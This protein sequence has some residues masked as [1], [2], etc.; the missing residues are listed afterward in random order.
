MEILDGSKLRFSSETFDDLMLLAREFGH[1]SLI[2]RLVPQRDF[3]RREGNVHELLQELHRSPRNPTIEAEFQSIHDGVAHVQRRL[4]VIEEKFGANF[5]TILSELDTMTELVRQ[6]N[7]KRPLNQRTLTEALIE[8]IGLRPSL[9]IR[10]LTHYLKK[11]FSALPLT[12]LCEWPKKQNAPA[13]SR[14]RFVVPT[15][16][17]HPRCHHSEE[18]D[19]GIYD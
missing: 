7:Q 19:Q 12:S 1:N 14:A 6:P 4:S 11:L 17:V 15:F 13:G 3:P 2:Q 10:L 8:W 5:A 9:S 16:S 18:N